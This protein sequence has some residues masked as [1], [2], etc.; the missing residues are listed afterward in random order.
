[1][2]VSFHN[3]TCH[4]PEDL[5]L[6]LHCC[7]NI[8]CPPTTHIYIYMTYSNVCVWVKSEMDEI[9]KLKMKLFKS[10]FNETS[11]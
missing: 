5:N 8:M 11:S 3:T 10:E 6:N 1:M 4:N 2:L 7:E 9:L